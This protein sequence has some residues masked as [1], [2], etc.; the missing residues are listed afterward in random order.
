M[1]QGVSF[2]VA[3]LLVVSTSGCGFP[4][5]F[6][7]RGQ[8][9]ATGEL[10]E[11]PQP[12]GD[13]R[14][15]GEPE[16]GG[17]ERPEVADRGALGLPEPIE[18]R[19]KKETLEDLAAEVSRTRNGLRLTA[20]ASKQEY[21]VDE[22]IV[23]DVRIENRSG[24]S[25]QGRDGGRDIPV[26]FEPFAK[27]PSGR[28]GEW[29]FKFLVRDADSQDIVYRSDRFE[30]P[31]SER[32]KYY[33]FVTLPEDAYVGRRFVLPPGNLKPGDYTFLVSYE[34]SD[35]FPYVI[36]NRRLS[37]K[38]V[39]LL[40]SKLAYVRVWTG[41]LYSNPVTVTIRREGRSWWPF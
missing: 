6:G 24:H 15:S 4:W 8:A 9:E 18:E 29:L 14:P 32:A 12:T 28:P 17:P 22:P 34:V 38:Q 16:G 11:A 40:G 7:G 19:F 35:E 21:T 23:L 5:L 2:V 39:Q 20:S 13:A 37:A 27:K 25:K 33:H 10:G 26:Y 30:V 41:K 1:R 36:I 3:T 31:E